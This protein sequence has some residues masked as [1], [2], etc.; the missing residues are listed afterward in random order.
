[1]LL[2]LQLFPFFTLLFQLF[3][4]FEG[5]LAF[6]S[7]LFTL[8]L[9]FLLTLLFLFL[10]AQSLCLFPLSCQALFLELSLL[11]FPDTLLFELLS[12]NFSLTGT[13]DVITTL[14]LGLDGP[15]DNRKNFFFLLLSLFGRLRQL[16]IEDLLNQI[17]IKGQVIEHIHEGSFDQLGRDDLSFLLGLIL[18]LSA[19]VMLQQ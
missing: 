3:F 19:D 12:F 15:V 17:H 6:L 14:L 4:F 2:E 11:L 5:Q 8:Q 13:L 9:G 7:F 18:T 1:M 16:F 10:Q